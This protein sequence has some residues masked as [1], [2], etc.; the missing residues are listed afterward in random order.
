[1]GQDA[2]ARLESLPLYKLL[3]QKEGKDH[4]PSELVKKVVEEVAPLLETVYANMPEFTLHDANHSANV[5][6][7]M[8]KIIPE[9]TLGSLNAVELTLLLL[10]AYLHDV[11]MTASRDEV[12]AIIKENPG[13]QSSPQEAARKLTAYLRAN[14]VNRSCE[15]IKC[16]FHDGTFAPPVK[17]SGELFIRYLIA[18]CDSH[19]LPVKKLEDGRVYPRAALIEDRLYINVQ[20]LALAL[21]MADLLDF[22]PTRT[23]AV[24]YRF[25][26]PQNPR[27][28]SEWNKHRGIVGRDV[29]SKFFCFSALCSAPEIQRDILDFLRQIEDERKETLAL[30]KRIHDD[31]AQKYHFD[32]EDSVSTERI[33]SDGSYIYSDFKFALDYKRVMELLMGE[34]LYRDPNVA[35]RELLQNAFDTIK[36]RVCVEEQNGTADDYSPLV[37]VTMQDGLLTV[38]DNGMGMDEYILKHYF[39]NIG[40]SYYSSDDFP[41]DKEQLDVTSEFGI[42]ILSV[43]MIA[44]SITVESRRFPEGSGEFNPIYIEIPQAQDYF[45]QRESKRIN[46]G[47]KITLK[48]KENIKL[49]EDELVKTIKEL[50]PFPTFPV[51]IIAGGECCRFDKPEYPEFEKPPVYTIDLD[52]ENLEGKIYIGS[53]AEQHV[54]AQKG[55][56]I[57]SEILMQ[58][59]PDFYYP[60][61]V[62]TIN[63]INTIG[64]LYYFNIKG[65]IRLTLT[66]DRTDA[67]RDERLEQLQSKIRQIVLTR[68]GE[69]FTKELKR[70]EGDRRRYDLYISELLERRG[71]NQNFHN[72]FLSKAEKDFLRKFIPLQTYDSKGCHR[73]SF[74]NELEDVPYKL[75]LDEKTSGWLGDFSQLAR[76]LQ[77][78]F[79]KDIVLIVS[80][81]FKHSSRAGFISMLFNRIDCEIILRNAIG[82]SLCSFSEEQTACKNYFDSRVAF[83]GIMQNAVFNQVLFT[84]SARK[85]S[86]YFNLKHRFF[87]CIVDVNSNECTIILHELEKSINRLINNKTDYLAE[88]SNDVMFLKDIS[89]RRNYNILLFGVFQKCPEFLDEI[90]DI[91][92]AFW[93]ELKQAGLVPKNKRMPR[94]TVDD[95]PWFWNAPPEDWKKYF[96]HDNQEE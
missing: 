9:D 78:Y 8:G 28:K 69:I 40:N 3:L 81:Y 55:F 74:F 50:V 79:D 66:P 30:S 84:I 41:Y 12:K 25:V 77:S 70:L 52:D 26:D 23:P 24:L 89:N 85:S 13:F 61:I 4:T 49:T 14:H 48:L 58:R 80:P 20:Y 1:M 42:G 88:N 45:I 54:I 2:L 43:F 92:K 51:N 36:H 63:T 6:E 32:F 53:Y 68:M 38:E 90:I 60:L 31:I 10:A 34:R 76:D 19:D 87:T 11:G 59:F 72:N 75:V 22:D 96:L 57:S 21:R 64:T 35:L 46:Y 67:L 56:K 94:L 47:T 15:Q 5:A 65:K 62:N 86:L 16:W 29:N 73:I 33:E 93:K 39:I 82:I 44:Q 71:L 91:F 7:L 18:I 83:S 95:F 37:K 17:W 27:S